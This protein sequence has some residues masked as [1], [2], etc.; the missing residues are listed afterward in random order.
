MHCRHSLTN[1]H[2]LLCNASDAAKSQATKSTLT[3]SY[4]CAPGERC[5][6]HIA[7]GSAGFQGTTAIHSRTHSNPQNSRHRDNPLL[8]AKCTPYIV[9]SC[10]T[11]PTLQ[12]PT[13]DDLTNAFVSYLWCHC[14][15]ASS[16][17]CT[18]MQPLLLWCL[19][20]P[21]VTIL[22]TKQLTEL[23]LTVTA[24]CGYKLMPVELRSAP[25]CC[26]AH[27]CFAVWQRAA[28]VQH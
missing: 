14:I 15:P 5:I 18:A 1:A 3:E 19:R 8:S 13:A 17:M 11:V 10:G 16:C 25:Y 2:Q 23:H 24:G 9:P 26:H 12:G 27:L 4:C 7:V 6:L 21:A 22:Q 20:C 28:Q